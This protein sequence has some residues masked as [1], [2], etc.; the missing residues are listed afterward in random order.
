MEL[1]HV[2]SLYHDDVMDEADIRRGVTS[3]NLRY[4]NTIAILV[5]D[6]LFAR[7]SGRV[8]SLGVDFVDLQARTFADLVEGQIAETTGP[9]TGRRPPGAPPEC[10]CRQDGITHPYL[11]TVRR[12]AWRRCP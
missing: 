1:T 7:A 12:H 11:C 4:G 2:A 6:F 9:A 5:G 3:A 10:D 8:A